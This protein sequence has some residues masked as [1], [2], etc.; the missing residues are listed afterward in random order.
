MIRGAIF[1]MDGVLLD[2]NGHWE[3]AA[4]KYLDSLGIESQPGLAQAIFEMTLPQAADYLIQ[5]YGVRQ[6]PTEILEGCNAV[7][8]EFYKS[9]IDKKEG[10][11]ELLDS[12]QMQGIPMIVAT[13]TDR[14]LV[15]AGL[16]RHGL[17][18]FFEGIVTAAEVG[19]GKTSPRI[20]L[21]AAKRIKR[22]PE[23]TLVFEDALHALKT[24]GKAGFVTVG[25]YDAYSEE[26]QA[27]LEQAARIYL[28]DYRDPSAV[29][30]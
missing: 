1:D 15:E 8:L 12:L 25:V 11:R 9:E 3:K 23:E 22:K 13:V 18:D 30:K 27:E 4:E 20:F 29:L 7:M 28:K 2:S 19:E 5:T 14:P 16:L 10:I 26:K 6:S 24:A 21:E 17:L